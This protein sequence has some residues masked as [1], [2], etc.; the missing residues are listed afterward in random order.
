MAC[1]DGS[2]PHARRIV[3]HRLLDCEIEN[4][5]LVIA[6]LGDF[7]A[8]RAEGV[9]LKS[10]RDVDLPVNLLGIEASTSPPSLRGIGYAEPPADVH[11]TMWSTTSACRALDGDPVPPSQGGQAM[12]AF[13]GGAAILVAGL[14][15]PRGG[16]VSDAAFA[17]VWDTRTGRK[18]APNSLGTH[19]VSWATATPFGEG[20]LVAGGI[21]RKFFPLRYLDSALVL[22]DG[23]FQ[24]PPISIGDPR[25]Q[26]GAVVLASG[27][28]LLVGGE[29]EHGVV[30]TLVSITPIDTAPYGV[31]D[32]F[33]LGSLVRARKSPTVLRLSTDEILVAGGLDASGNAVST[34]EW[35]SKDGGPCARATCSSEPPELAELADVAFIALTGGGALAVGGVAGAAS[36]PANGVFWIGHDGTLEKLR[37][38]TAGQ[39]G[40][41]R[42]RLVSAGDGSPWLWNG[43]AWFRFD[44]WQ[45]AFVTPDDAPDDGPDDDLPPPLAVDPGL[46]VWLSRAGIADGSKSAVLRG[47]RHGARGPYTHDPDFLLA[48]PR[49]VAPSRPPRSEGELWTDAEGLHLSASA[50]VVIAD[51]TYGNFVSSGEAAGSSLPTF[52]LGAWTV[53]PPPASCPWPSAGT[54]FTVTRSGRSVLVKVDDGATTSCAGPEGRVSL[55][56]HGPGPETVTVKRLTVERR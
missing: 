40:T 13:G 38:L 35:F 23:A 2:A 8:A 34:L 9:D 7:A 54:R 45:S 12:T 47:F 43:D 24:E 56:L 41:K 27:A 55:G 4:S 37:S 11:L 1:Q 53:G 33:M 10:A 36:A 50:S 52:A 46:F 32:F 26:H 5:K 16:A 19:R 28:T 21:D 17:L 51:T 18:L 22:R 15:P 44:P 6:A 49:H 39:R 20:A 29:D 25:A 31:A 30:D 3:P 42:L 48:D 14:D